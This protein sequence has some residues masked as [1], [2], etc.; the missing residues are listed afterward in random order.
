MCELHLALQDFYNVINLKYST[1]VYF[2]VVYYYDG[3]S[4]HVG[5]TRFFTI[6]IMKCSFL[7]E[8]FGFRKSQHQTCSLQA[9][10]SNYRILSVFFTLTKFILSL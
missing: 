7:K 6:C 1:L 3:Q 8:I 5:S 10:T 4:I 2:D 9:L